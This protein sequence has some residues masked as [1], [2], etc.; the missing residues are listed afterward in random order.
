MNEIINKIND[1]CN[2]PELR[3]KLLTYRWPLAIVFIIIL[4][5]LMKP[6]HFWF[7][8]FI[9]LIGEG[10]QV[11]CFAALNKKK[12]LAARGP[13][14]VVRNPMYI[15][16]YFLILGAVAI[17]G[18]WLLAILFTII[19]Y[20][21]MI[22]RVEREEAVLIEIF[23]SDYEDYCRRVNRFLPAFHNLDR[24][25]IKYFRWDLFF[26]NNAHLNLLAVAAGYLAVYLILF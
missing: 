14:A 17:T 12:E 16:R 9:S 8:L 1:L 25:A 22:N 3:N 21:Y 11:W 26:Q 24:E 13:Y 7:G 4:V 5:F 10:L 6:Q 15:G 20:F 23:G 18:S 19:Y 2:D